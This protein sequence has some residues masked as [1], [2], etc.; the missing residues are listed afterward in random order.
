MEE[1]GKGHLG[2]Y[3]PYSLTPRP[4]WRRLGCSLTHPNLGSHTPVAEGPPLSP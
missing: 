4:G 2:S 1:L 3:V